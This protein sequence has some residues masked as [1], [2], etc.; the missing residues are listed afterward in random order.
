M[1]PPFLRKAAAQAAA[2]STTGHTASV[3]AVR[4]TSRGKSLAVVL[5]TSPG[6]QVVLS[7]EAATRMAD[8]LLWAAGVASAANASADPVAGLASIPPQGRA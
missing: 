7:P 3:N 2:I 4:V 6:T 8:K 5:L 1:R